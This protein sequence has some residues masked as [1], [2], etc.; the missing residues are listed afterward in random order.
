MIAVPVYRAERAPDQQAMLQR[1]WKNVVDTFVE[2][3]R[4]ALERSIVERFEQVVDKHADH[5]AVKAKDATL[6][7][8]ALNQQANRL[9]RAV[10]ARLGNE[11]EPVALLFE[12]GSTAIAAM[13]GMLKAG[14]IYVALDPI[15]P[16]ERL[17]SF[18]TDSQCR[19][20]LTNHRNLELAKQ[21]APNS[22]SEILAI[23]E[24]NTNINDDNLNLAL[25][26][27]T[28]ASIIYTSGSTGQPKGGIQN[29]RQI[30]HHTMTLTNHYRI[31]PPDRQPQFFSYSY[32]V[33]LSSIY[34]MLLNGAMLIPSELDAV[35]I[36]KLAEWLI[37]NQVTILHLPPQV[38]RQFFESL[39]NPDSNRMPRLRVIAV[40]GGTITSQDV[41]LWLSHLSPDCVISHSLATTEAIGTARFFIDHDTP[42]PFETIP[43]GYP[44]PDKEILLIDEIGL[45]VDSGRVGEIVV[46]SRYLTPG[47]WHKPDLTD[48][49]FKQDPKGSD[50]RL[51]FSG[52]LGRWRPDGLL[53]LVGRKDFQ[54]KIRGYT[55]Q[56]GEVE[57]ALYDLGSIKEAV[58]VALPDEKGNQRLVAYLVSKSKP[59]PAVGELRAQLKEK[60]PSHA[61]PAIFV[62]LDSLPRT[63]NS[64]VDRQALPSPTTARPRLAQAYVPA[65]N[66]LQATLI[67]LWEDA[68]GING[69]GIQDDFFDLGG[70]S[71]KA[72]ELS[73]EIEAKFGK[74]LT[75]STLLQAPTIE[76]LAAVIAKENIAPWQSVIVAI[77][78]EGS[79]PPLFLA[80]GFGG[81][82]FQYASLARHLGTDQP[83]YG[84]QPAQANPPD[85]NFEDIVSHYVDELFE[86]YPSGP[87]LL[88]GYSYGAAVAFEI[89]R[90]IEERGRP[91]AF[92]ASF[93]FTLAA[94]YR[95]FK[96]RPKIGLGFIKNLP[97]WLYGFSRLDAQMKRATVDR[98]IR[99]LKVALHNR[100]NV[101]N[102]M[103]TTK[104][105]DIAQV[106]NTTSSE[107]LEKIEQEWALV[108]HHTFKPYNGRLTLF[109]AQAQPFLCSFDPEMNWSELVRGGVT[110][111]IVPDMHIDLLSERNMPV[112][113]A[114]LKRCLEQLQAAK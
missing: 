62:Y 9:A 104:F 95:N 26:S 86:F 27:D 105:E 91:V 31:C 8:A 35:G 85:R 77:Q 52:D 33:I 23:E 24:I 46:K 41:F 87:Y 16:L 21:L 103:T 108:R 59:E 92:L 28:Y 58:V 12:R 107:Q 53:E 29:H 112:V 88:A 25:S 4:A 1:H 38:Y 80:H 84:I 14:K 6:T 39:P 13:F 72:E 19:L 60:L 79:R 5:I 83:V 55:V 109:R 49:L 43:V 32:S 113:A 69:I 7:Y 42:L 98:G 94:G 65:T 100:R 90:Q 64:K 2:F 17:K 20:I 89:A 50:Q 47:Y 78:P 101:L 10:N 97:F 81:G 15:Y 37:E 54:V 34:P 71:L 56:I 61:I 57:M 93:D 73:L 18:L 82:L 11:N 111:Q 66:E 51:Y 36:G 63:P 99:R 45:P 102:I 74:H 68:L 106:I 3:P 44:E 70:D 30:L 110:L 114:K 40:G 67:E 76:K 22:Q 48:A 75:A 96:M